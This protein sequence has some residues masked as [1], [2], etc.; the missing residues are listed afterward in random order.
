MVHVSALTLAVLF[1]LFN[2]SFSHREHQCHDPD[3]GGTTTARFTATFKTS[4]TAGFT[5]RF[6]SRFIA[7]FIVRFK[8]RFTVSFTAR[9]KSY[10]I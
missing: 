9:F 3:V 8:T 4:L 6:K 5:D 1:L 10:S 2:N 7:R